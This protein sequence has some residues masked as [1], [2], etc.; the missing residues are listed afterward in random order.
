MHE[1]VALAC[2]TCLCHAAAYVNLEDTKWRWSLV[3]FRMVKCSF[4]G[5][6]EQSLLQKFP[7]HW[8]HAL[9]GEASDH[10]HRH[11]VLMAW[12]ESCCLVPLLLTLVHCLKVLDMHECKQ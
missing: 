6:N 7:P 9:T 10:L 12:Q 1:K 4:D 5:T 2:M 3:I 8:K 11:S